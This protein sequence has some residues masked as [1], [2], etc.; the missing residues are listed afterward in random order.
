MPWRCTPSCPTPSRSAP[1]LNHT[2]FLRHFLGIAT[3]VM[4]TKEMPLGFYHVTSANIGRC[5]Q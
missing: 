5:G 1:Q 2:L 3:F 4:G